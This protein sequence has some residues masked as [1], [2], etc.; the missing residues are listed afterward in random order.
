MALWGERDPVLTDSEAR[1][2]ALARRANSQE[3]TIGRRR[4]RS[5]GGSREEQG[6]QQAQRTL[7][8]DH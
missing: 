2:Y 6:L 8:A 7:I 4:A 3:L 1:A 5:R